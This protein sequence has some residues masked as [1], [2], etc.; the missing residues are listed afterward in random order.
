MA[1]TYNMTEKQV[2]FLK[3][4]IS[5][6]T[7]FSSQSV[8]AKYKIGSQGNIQRIQDSLENAEIIMM[9]VHGYE[10]CEPYFKPWFKRMFMGEKISII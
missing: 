7:K 8:L 4:F 2:N 1:L 6:E 3:A 10:F 5:G 9:G